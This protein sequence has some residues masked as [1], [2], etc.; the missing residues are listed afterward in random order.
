MNALKK[1]IKIVKLELSKKSEFPTA[2]TSRNILASD[3]D[4]I[5]ENFKDL[6]FLDDRPKSI[7]H[8]QPNDGL[9]S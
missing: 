5:S 6:N 2:P 9:Q 1:E 3:Q 4:P 8:H 7:I